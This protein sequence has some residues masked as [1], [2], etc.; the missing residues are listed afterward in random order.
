MCN[1]YRKECFSKKNVY[2]WAEHGFAS[3]SLCQQRS[4]KWKHI[5]SPGKKTFQM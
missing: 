5:D 1:V 2:R 4:M 3:M